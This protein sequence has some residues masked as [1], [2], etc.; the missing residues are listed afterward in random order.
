MAKLPITGDAD[1]DRLLEENSL[2]LMIGMLLDQQVPMEW[3]FSAPKLL[4]E[5]LG[6]LDA[7]TIASLGPEKVEEVFRQKPALH[8]YPGSMAKRAYELC[9]VL[10]DEYDGRA[11]AVWTSASDGADLLKRLKALPGYGEEK[12]RIFVAILG[13]RFGVAPD[14]WREAAGP[15]GE[16][17]PRSVADV[18]GPESLAR[19]REFKKAK[20]AQGKG[21]AD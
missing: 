1:A 2:A 10:V 6:S 13:K 21:K 12:S 4:E 11:D 19:V 20:K 14:G 15:F 9:R 7:T 17:T 18:D 16:D 8:R 5:R 3:A